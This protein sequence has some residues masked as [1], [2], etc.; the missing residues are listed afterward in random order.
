M[1]HLPTNLH[2]SPLDAWINGITG[3]DCLRQSLQ[4]YQTLKLR[5][6][7][8]RAKK[9]SPFYR[10]HLKD[11][12]A[13][14]IELPGG[15]QRIPFTNAAELASEQGR[16]VCVS[17]DA[18]AHIVT[19]TSSGTSGEPKRLYFSAA[20]QERTLDFFAHGVATL[21]GNA[22]T[23]L[24]ALPGQRQGGVGSLLAEGISRAG[25][26][27]VLHGLIERAE[28]TLQTVVREKA[29]C[30][31]GFP[32]QMLWLASQ[33][34]ALAEE[35][36]T[37][38]HSV[39]VCS[40]YV[41]GP[42]V[43]RLQA[44]CGCEVYEHYGMTEMGMGGGVDCEAHCGY[45]LREADL[46]FEIVDPESGR[47]LPDG[48][49]GEVVFTTLTREAM[50]LIRYRTGDLS[51][52]SANGCPCGSELRNLERIQG[53]TKGGVSLGEEGKISITDLDEVLFAIPGV[54][55]FKARLVRGAN[56]HLEVT[57]CL[58]FGDTHALSQ[59]N[60]ALHDG[61]P[62]I[63]RAVRRGCLSVEVM[64]VSQPFAFSGEKRKIEVLTEL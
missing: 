64:A 44:L 14:R 58:P 61:I 39:V 27:P 12:D 3:G 47:T 17:Q 57:C 24:I 60:A 45:H 31:I 9:N 20:D 38:L 29:T 4:E 16:F 22:D 35:A 59:A 48:E 10:E 62:A 37:M 49:T 53:R 13:Q 21:A 7:L 52:F 30:M 50:P 56:E 28:E 1:S 40:D 43:Q 55:D 34:S 8:I 2:K 5:E 11:V 36:L 26:R 18:I 41:P 63:G 46:L 19:L 15:L 42:L 32:V 25:V 6:T 51:R 54:V 23:M 33:R